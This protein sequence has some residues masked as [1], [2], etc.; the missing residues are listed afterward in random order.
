MFPN[1]RLFIFP[2]VSDVIYDRCVFTSG[3]QDGEPN[4]GFTSQISRFIKYERQRSAYNITFDNVKRCSHLAQLPT[5]GNCPVSLP[6]FAV[7]FKI[8]LA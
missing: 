6:A 1:W 8:T 3:A 4:L 7:V 2:D 5:P